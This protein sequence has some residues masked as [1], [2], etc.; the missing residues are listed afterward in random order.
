MNGTANGERPRLMRERQ[1]LEAH[2]ASLR[3][4]STLPPAH[5]P[6]RGTFLHGFLLPF[7]LIAATLRDAELR[8]PYLRVAAARAAVVAVVTAVALAGGCISAKRDS[9]AS[10]E[11]SADVVRTPPLP[12][13]KHAKRGH[14]R[15]EVG[16]LRIDVDADTPK[17][18]AALEGATVPAPVTSLSRVQALKNGAVG[19]AR[20]GWGWLL[21]FVTF[22]SIVQALVVF[23]SRRWDD[24][25]SLY[26]SRIAGIV[27]D[28]PTPKAP[29]LAL[30]LPWLFRKVKRRF[31]GHVVFLI[32]LP[33]LTPLYLVPTVGDALFTAMAT[34]WGLYWVGVFAASKSG[35]AWADE[36]RASL[37]A[38]LRIY[39]ANLPAAAPFA[40]LR[41]YGRIWTRL[42]KSIAP[43]STTFERSP[44]AFW[45]LALA[46]TVLALPGLYLLARPVV[47]VAAGRICA[48]SDPSGRFFAPP[49]PTG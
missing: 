16:D 26:V 25:L 1:A 33:L 40:P 18:E 38:P 34:G 36:E 17:A 37:P 41:L 35:H 32:G 5:A 29:A 6:V 9:G 14:T 19:F 47:P 42:T 49:D 31:R 10:D 11:A 3:G 8:R 46:R 12:P 39:A 23:V 48:E 30:D 43:A 28:D 4:A 21:A 45:G 7:S 20:R 13:T 27:P 15:V 44:A 22:L 2:Y 24:H